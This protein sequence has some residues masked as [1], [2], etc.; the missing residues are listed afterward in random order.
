MDIAHKTFICHQDYFPFDVF[1]PFKYVKAILMSWVLQ[2]R[3]QARSGQ[4]L[5]FLCPT[6]EQYNVTPGLRAKN[7]IE[8]WYNR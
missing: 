5:P 6:P 4:G 3:R 2:H 7:L 8:S 1:Q